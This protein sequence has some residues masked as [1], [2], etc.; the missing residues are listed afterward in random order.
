[1]GG[2]YHAAWPPTVLGGLTEFERH[3]NVSGEETLMDITRSYKSV[4]ERSAAHYLPG[5]RI[6]GLGLVLAGPG[7]GLRILGVNG[8]SP[9]RPAQFIAPRN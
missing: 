2:H 1:M 4:T 9:F 5:A 8:A 7:R 6:V 3:I